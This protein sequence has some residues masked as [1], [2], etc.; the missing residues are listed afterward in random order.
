MNS[1]NHPSTPV[2]TTWF[3]KE[4]QVRK[5]S[6]DVSDEV[7]DLIEVIS[8]INLNDIFI[9]PEDVPE[10]P[11]PIIIDD[12]PIPGDDPITEFGED[13]PVSRPL[14]EEELA[15]LRQINSNEKLTEQ[16]KSMLKKLGVNDE[17]TP[18]PQIGS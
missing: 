11:P 1:L 5:Y 14:T 10:A 4:F 8:E 15:D 6:H 17:E 18:M 13:G 2:K 9:H 7:E 3:I 16:V 12:I